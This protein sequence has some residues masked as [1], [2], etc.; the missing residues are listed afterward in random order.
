MIKILGTFI[1]LAITT[2]VG[3]NATSDCQ[4]SGAPVDYEIKDARDVDPQEMPLKVQKGM[5][6]HQNAL[7]IEPERHEVHCYGS[8]SAFAC[9]GDGWWCSCWKANSEWDCGCN[10]GSC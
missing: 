7:G 8:V 6:Q 2:H 3:V 10:T 1:V 4:T 9:S 5:K